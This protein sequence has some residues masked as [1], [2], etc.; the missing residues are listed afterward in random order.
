NPTGVS[1]LSD[2]ALDTQNSLYFLDF[3]DD[4]TGKWIVQGSLPQALG[5]PTATPTFTTLYHDTSASEIEGIQ[6]DDANQKLYFIEKNTF[7]RLN[8]NTANQTPTLLGSAATVSGGPAFIDGLTVDLTHNTAYFY[9][10]DISST[11]TFTG[12]M[13]SVPHFHSV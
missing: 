6:V 3:S 8:Y 9:T 12:P 2:V 5:T 11:A 7:Q 10:N 1:H 13:S 4:T